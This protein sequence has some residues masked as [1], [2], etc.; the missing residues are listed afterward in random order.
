MIVHGGKDLWVPIRQIQGFVKALKDLDKPHEAH[1]YPR[2]G[3]ILY[4]FSFP[5][6]GTTGQ[7]SEWLK[8]QVWEWK[9]SQD[10]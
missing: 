9:N 3:H 10:V 2:E 5:D 7:I 1:I 8:P 4:L 6:I